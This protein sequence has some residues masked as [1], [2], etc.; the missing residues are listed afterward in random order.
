VSIDAI[1]NASIYSSITSDQNTKEMLFEEELKSVILEL[2]NKSSLGV[3]QAVALM[4][5]ERST[6]EEAAHRLGCSIEA[7]KKRLQRGTKVLEQIIKKEE[8][9]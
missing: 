6:P 4:F 5:F 9:K 1:E 8:T 2:K 7:L 3:Y